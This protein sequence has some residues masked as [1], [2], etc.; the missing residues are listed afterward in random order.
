MI[1][2]IGADN[3]MASVETSTAAL[4]DAVPYLKKRQWRKYATSISLVGVFF[5]VGLLFCSRAGFYW[6]HFFDN[7]SGCKIFLYSRN[8]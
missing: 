8:C 4:L 5:L 1:L 6:V 3:L 7:F 2:I